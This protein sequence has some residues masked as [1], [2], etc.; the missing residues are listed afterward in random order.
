[1][2][3]KAIQ[4]IEVGRVFTIEKGKRKAHYKIISHPYFKDAYALISDH[5]YLHANLPNLDSKYIC[6]ASKTIEGVWK[7]AYDRT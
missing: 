6:G 7:Q 3:S 1:M 4:N 5:V 2:E